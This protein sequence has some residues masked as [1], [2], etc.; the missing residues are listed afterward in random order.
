MVFFVLPHG[1]KRKNI[2]LYSTTKLK[3]NLL[4]HSIHHKADLRILKSSFLILEA[5][6]LAHEIT[7][8]PDATSIFP[9]LTSTV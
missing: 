3:I 4:C 5:G 1:K 7:I 9:Q 6:H 2:F 8:W